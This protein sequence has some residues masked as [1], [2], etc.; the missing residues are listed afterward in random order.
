[1][2]I[3]ISPRRARYSA[4]PVYQHVQFSMHRCEAVCLIRPFPGYNMPDFLFLQSPYTDS[5]NG[6]VRYFKVTN[7]M[8]LACND[9][10]VHVQKLHKY[11]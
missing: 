4:S 8:R 2:R 10:S 9:M 3:K 11:Q 5:L 7:V 6:S 1:M